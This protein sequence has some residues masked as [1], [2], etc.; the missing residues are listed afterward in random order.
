MFCK[1]LKSAKL[2]LSYLLRLTQELIYL[3]SLLCRG[4]P[5]LFI[6]SAALKVA[7]GEDLILREV[8]RT[9]NT[10]CHIAGLCEVVALCRLKEKMERKEERRKRGSFCFQKKRRL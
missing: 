3:H 10:S 1:K 4:L 2:L 5:G 8:N 7:E 6:A 9:N